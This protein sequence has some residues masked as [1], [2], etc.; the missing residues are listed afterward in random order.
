MPRRRP[1]VLN[2]RTNELRQ[3]ITRMTHHLTLPRESRQK[4]THPADSRKIF[5]ANSV[6]VVNSDIPAFQADEHRQISIGPSALPLWRPQSSFPCRHICRQE[7]IVKWSS[8]KSKNA[9]RP[10]VPNRHVYSAQGRGANRR[11]ELERVYRAS[12]PKRQPAAL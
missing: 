8:A 3:R 12:R 5:L 2:R 1:G 6:S 11:S 7:C 4:V 9:R 10:D